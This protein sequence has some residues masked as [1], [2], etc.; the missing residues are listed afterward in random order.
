MKLN[1]EK[2]LLVAAELRQ[3]VE[4]LVRTKTV[5]AHPPRDAKNTLRLV[6]ELEVHRIELEM[7]NEELRC[8]QEQIEF[9]RNKYVELYDFAP[10]GYFTFDARGLIREANLTGAHL[11]GIER[12]M[13]V[14]KP[15]DRFIAAEEG[16]DLF[17]KHLKSVLQR[18]GLQRCELRLRGKDGPAFY[19]QLQSIAVDTSES[20]NGYILSSLVDC[21]LVKQAEEALLKAGAL[22]SA[23][24]NSANFSSIATDAQGVIQIFNVG[25]ERMLG[26]TAAEVM[27]K[28]TPADISDPQEVVARAE[29]LSI[30]LDTAITP[31]FEALVFKASRGIEDIYELTYIR[32]DGSR[33]PAVVSVTA[34]R[35]AQ[36]VIIGY[37]LIGT[38]NT[39]RKEAEEALLKAGALQA[40][41]FNSENFSSIATDAN[42]V[43]QL[44]NVGAKSTWG[45]TA[46]EAV[47]KMTPADISDPQELIVRAESL[48]VEFATTITPGFE[49][50]VFKASRGIEDIYELTKIRKDGSRFPAILSVTALRNAQNE[51]IGYLLIVTDNTARKKAEAEEQRLLAIQEEMN[52]E[53]QEAK[54]TAEVANRLK[55]EFLANMS[56]EIRTPLNAIIGFSTLAMKTDLSAKQQ[57]YIRKIKDSGVSLL[58]IVNEILDFSK[59]EADK[60]E[61][62]QALFT[63]DEVLLS[64]IAVVE[65]KAVDK[66][67]ELLLDVSPEIPW[68]LVGDSLRLGQI[69]TNLVG[70]AIKFTEKGEVELSVTLQERLKSRVK[71]QFS[72]RDTG[73]GIS[74][75]HL[76][77]LFHAFSQA[78]GSMTR[79]FGG[80]GLGLSI[81]KRLAEM[82]EGDIWAESEPGTGSTFSFTAWFHIESAENSPP[83]IPET[84]NR[85]KILVV[86]DDDTCRKKMITL[87]SRF[88][89]RV[90]TV[91]S[92]NE[93]F[94]AIKNQ[95]PADPYKL[96]L[97]D[98]KTSERSEG[99]GAARRIKEYLTLH[100]IPSIIMVTSFG[101]SIEQAEASK[102]GADYF[103]R[104]PVTASSL[105][106]AIIR[107]LTPEERGTLMGIQR[108][109][110]TTFNFMAA[111]ILLVEDNEINQQLAIELLESA[112]LT[113]EVASNGREAVEMVTASGNSY[114]LVLMDIQM[115][116]MDGYEAA[117]CIRSDLR[118]RA[119]PI[120]A[121]S[122]HA[123]VEDRQKTVSVGMNDHIT[124]P[125]NPQVMFTAMGR[126]LR[127]LPAEKQSLASCNK[128]A[129]E[130]VAIPVIPGVDVK[131][132]LYR[133]S[134][135]V[136]LY[137][138]LLEKFILNQTGTA[139]AIESA[140]NS[141]DRSLAE[142]LAHTTKGVAGNIGA[143]KIQ[144]IAAELSASIRG[145]DSPELTG[146]ILGRFAEGMADLVNSLRLVLVVPSDDGIQASAAAAADDA[147]RVR[148]ILG[149]LLRYIKENDGKA[150]YYLGNCQRELVALPHAEMK[151]LGDC[152]AD[153]N[154]EEALISLSALAEKIGI[155]LDYG[156]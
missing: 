52:Q 5:S 125:I 148:T 70:N 144:N 133:L 89:A 154:Y 151:K 59:I 69:I 56:H 123:L 10:V 132:A 12:Q 88:P 108:D 139:A 117:R 146:E 50:L 155:S 71:L 48:S 103:L 86:D 97:M 55:S 36:E 47:G 64:V 147:A 104:R 1:K 118:F 122:A 82:M 137:L 67:I 105:F 22:Q 6:H 84:L 46:A 100:I 150:E 78:D 17:S 24:F 72:V 40:A 99:V 28:I 68:H 13:L 98:W 37:L 85:M 121:M 119:L 58:G 44:F 62:E 41:I 112:G 73:I 26:Y 156:D 107:I 127:Q 129:A 42:G 23:I 76:A 106:D 145:N 94:V 90:D 140:L 7:Q 126:Y 15:F 124:K 130:Q 8:A 152:L 153:F 2:S 131:G 43:I 66:N 39:A 30:E 21:T 91:K 81:S 35:D 96:I 20:K 113:V 111:R 18:Q 93:A 57:D 11:L 134:G 54:E 16:R 87:L 141:G 115:P 101:S 136:K 19:G 142:R 109:S 45:Y 3:H 135:N 4:K 149:Q 38:D 138:Q 14:D 29:A 31:G 9:S 33:F 65:Q 143:K 27:N 80:T 77:K 128:N 110:E 51:I 61:M 120:L 75:E 114:D 34:L 79:R 95:N 102:V 92:G 53:L 60:L 74:P 32:K 63:L 116:E 83:L 25:A 49:A